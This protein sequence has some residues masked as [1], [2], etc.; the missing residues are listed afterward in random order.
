MITSLEQMFPSSVLLLP[1]EDILA[2][3][4][5]FVLIEQLA[6]RPNQMYT[7]ESV[8]GATVATY[9]NER[10]NLGFSLTFHGN[11]IYLF[12]FETG[13][14]IPQQDI[15]YDEEGDETA[16]PQR[17]YL[18]KLIRGTYDCLWFPNI[19]CQDMDSLVQILTDQFYESANASYNR[20]FDEWFHDY[21]GIVPDD[22]TRDRIQEILIDTK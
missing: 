18:F 12:G 17:R 5:A 3:M 7:V 1:P 9:H 8:D 2:K 11:S 19:C 4:R 22:F 13:S 20:L 10:E 21:P 16:P 15:Y 6:E 14:D